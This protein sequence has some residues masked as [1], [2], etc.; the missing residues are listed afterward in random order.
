MD[1]ALAEVEGLQFD[2]EA[3][4]GA[5]HGGRGAVDEESV[6]EVEDGAR[7]FGVGVRGPVPDDVGGGD[8]GDDCR[9]RDDAATDA[10]PARRGGRAGVVVDPFGE[11]C[12]GHGGGSVGCGAGAKGRVDGVAAA[13]AG[14]GHRDLIAGLVGSDGGAERVG[15]VDEGAVDLRDD[16]TGAESRLCGR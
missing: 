14:V 3:V 5:V 12:E 16:V 7:L 15:A 13:V 6:A 4:V 10:P 9:G 2:G 1:E 11:R 8:E